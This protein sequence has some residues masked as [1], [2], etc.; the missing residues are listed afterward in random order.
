MDFNVIE[1]RNLIVISNYDFVIYYY[2][3]I[4]VLFCNYYF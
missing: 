4:F 2:K 3:I 1:G